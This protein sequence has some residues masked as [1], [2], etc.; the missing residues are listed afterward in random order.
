VTIY[1]VRH[2]KAGERHIWEGDDEDRPLSGRGRMQSRGLLAVLAD[3]K[4]DRLLSSPYVRCMETLI[5]LAAQRG[6]AIEPVGALAE[7]GGLED[8]VALVR[9]H[10]EHGA[11]LCTHGDIV[12]MLLSYY[13]ERGVDIGRA[14]QWPKGSTWALETDA[15]GEV[16]AT[17]YL[18]PP[19][20]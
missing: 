17:R 12:P 10:S 14:P 7:G 2:A 9:K 11:V 4:F 3:A 8:A 20:G 16:I 1:L 5:P 13:E 15:T 6:L 18:K 19:P